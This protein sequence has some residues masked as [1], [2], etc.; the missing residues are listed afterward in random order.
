MFQL[1][2]DGTYEGG[3]YE[4]GNSIIAPTATQT[5]HRWGDINGCSYVPGTDPAHATCVGQ[6]ADD[7]ATQSEVYTV[8]YS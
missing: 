6:F 4:E 7:G 5:Y 1:S 3:S 2:T 8:E